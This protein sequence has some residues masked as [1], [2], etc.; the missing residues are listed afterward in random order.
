MEFKVS[1]LSEFS[2]NVL[3]KAGVPSYE[4]DTITRTMIEADSRGIH[5]HGLMRLPIY[6]E[7][8]QKGFI[9]K[10]S[11]ITVEKEN[12]GTAVID[13]HFSAGQVVATKAMDMAIEK[14]NE[15]GIAAVSVK[16]SNHFG[17]AA[18]YA[19]KAAENDMIA[20]VMSNTAPLMPPTGG[21]EKVLG[22]NPLAIAAPSSGN[23][24]VLLDM[25]LSNVALGKV[26]FA[27]NNGVEIPEGWGTDKNGIPTTDPASVLDGGFILPVG[28]P[29]GF[30]LALMVELLT[31]VLSG[32][33]FSKMIPSMY[34]TTKKQ[35][36]SH[37]MI[38]INISS[39]MD[40]NTFKDLSETLGS[41]VKNAVK[42]PG[43]SQLYLPGEIEFG[44]EENRL[45]SGIPISDGVLED[46]AKLANTMNVTPLTEVI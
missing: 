23:N 21:A 26:L 28:G 14:A 19:L 12:K 11:K 13:G 27:K 40:V 9:R 25:A 8:M 18:H 44:V 4:A 17:I 36:I 5:S 35:S 32:G 2:N 20:I 46:L 3:M 24:P 45:K 31:G 41:Y 30:G 43:V 33:D 1:T 42:A 15:Y 10:E 16:N 38:A 39:F 37:L 6:I 7:R 22:N 29:K 34:D